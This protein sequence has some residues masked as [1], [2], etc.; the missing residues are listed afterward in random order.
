[1]ELLDLK[2]LS[3]DA[4]SKYDNI[5]MKTVIYKYKS[6]Y[7]I[8]YNSLVMVLSEIYGKIE[9]F[10]E[11]LKPFYYESDEYK[12]TTYFGIYMGIQMYN[13]KTQNKQRM[14]GEYYISYIKHILKMAGVN[15]LG[16]SIFNLY[17]TMDD[18]IGNKVNVD[19]YYTV[20]KQIYKLEFGKNMNDKISIY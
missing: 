7:Y 16:D 4:I 6:F 9:N 14:I 8:D 5:Y 19:E 10:E 12:L 13:N 18:I 2:K 1:M 3:S 15:Q 17:Y 11:Y 20:I